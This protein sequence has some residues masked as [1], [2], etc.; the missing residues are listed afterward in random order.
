ELT[1]RL[2][3]PKTPAPAPTS[4]TIA[5]VIS[6]VMGGNNAHSPSPAVSTTTINSG[7]GNLINT[8]TVHTGGGLL[9]LGD[10]SDQARLTIE[11]L[12]DQRPGAGQPS[13]RELLQELKASI[14]ADSHLSDTTRAEALGEL[15]ELATAAKD[16]RANGGPA[17]RAMNALKGLSAGLSETNK[18]VEESSK[19]V[20]AVKRLL[21]LIAGF[22][23]A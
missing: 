23:L 17:R 20:G 8:G 4:V 21:P 16:P 15:Q 5:P 22:F 7:D 3:P 2:V 18:A 12:P 1:G 11:A 6:P 13:L 19:L 10:L 14:D 9:H